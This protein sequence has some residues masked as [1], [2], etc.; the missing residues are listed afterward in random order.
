M[1]YVMMFVGL[2]TVA[3]IPEY[4]GAVH[5]VLQSMFG[6]FVFAIGAINLISTENNA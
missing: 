5:T 1:N 6:L 3:I 2:I 4:A